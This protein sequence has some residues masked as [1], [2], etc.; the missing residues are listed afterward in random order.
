MQFVLFRVVSWIVFSG[1]RRSTNSH[2]LTK[3][4]N[5]GNDKLKFIGHMPSR[6][7][8]TGGEGFN[9]TGDICLVRLGMTRAEV[10]TNLGD[11]DD[12][13]GTSRKYRNPAIWKYGDLEFHFGPKSEDR[14]WLIYMDED[15]VVRVQISSQTESTR[16]G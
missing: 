2:E 6:D 3:E 9:V 16:S 10:L 13:G 7:S 5:L 1:R 4:S 14:L 15:E 12:M 8:R 11:S